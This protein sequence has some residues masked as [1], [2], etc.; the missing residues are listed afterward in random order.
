MGMMNRTTRLAP[1]PTGALHLGNA[2]TFLINWL[3]ARRRGWRIVFRMEDLDTPRTQPMANHQA[4]DDLHWLGV[5]WDSRQEDQSARTEI[6]AAALQQL[7]DDGWA[8][9]CVCTRKEIERAA[10]A[11]A[12]ED[13]SSGA[14]PGTCRGRFTGAE[15]AE[16]LT[17]RQV[18]WRMRVEGPAVCFD[19]AVAGNQCW[20]LDETC[21]DVVVARRSGLAAYQLAVTVDDDAA[22][23][24]DIVRGD[25][26]LESAAIQLRVRERLGLPTDVTHWHLPLMIGPDGRKLAKRH[27]DTRLRHYIDSGV[28]C[29]RLLGF[30]AHSAGVLDRLCEISLTELLDEF[31]I[32][33]LSRDPFT[34]TAA[35]DDYLLTG[36]FPRTT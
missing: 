21:G 22:G 34:F 24:T 20:A 16:D 27:G 9:P 36:D 4:I 12:A 10:S 3:I 15:Q 26:L 32:G 19:D 29:E 6:Y 25:D 33:H 17:E 7:I 11:P 28:R 30:L 31:D 1:S 2:R 18:A 14:Y 8:Y 23:V 13:P 35:H 5:D